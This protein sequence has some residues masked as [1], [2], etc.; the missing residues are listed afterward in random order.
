MMGSSQALPE[1]PVE[2]TRFVEDLSEAEV[3]AA[4]NLPSG[5]RN[6]GNTCYM[7]AT[8]QCLRAVPE[9]KD[10]ISSQPPALESLDIQKA[11]VDSLRLL[12]SEM[13]KNRPD[14]ALTIFI[15]K[16]HVLVPHFSERDERSRAYKQQDAHECWQALITALSLN[17]PGSGEGGRGFMEQYFGLRL[18]SKFKCIENL[19][20][21][22]K[23]EEEES[24]QLSCFIQQGEDCVY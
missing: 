18:M 2:K 23:V 20:E 21:P 5:L 6:L 12:Y 10:V 8:V 19:D 15:Q 14:L 17:L 4:L 7:N 22:E 3:A 16:L 11:L 9:L 24:F 1:A 13:D